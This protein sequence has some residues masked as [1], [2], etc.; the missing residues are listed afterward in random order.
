M[1]GSNQDRDTERLEEANGRAGIL[2]ALLDELINVAVLPHGCWVVCRVL[3]RC[4]RVQTA[5]PG[6]AGGDNWLCT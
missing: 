2:S 3:K 1:Q 5:W 6:V 4:A